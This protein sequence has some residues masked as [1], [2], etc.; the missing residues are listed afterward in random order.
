MP[1]PD[2]SAAPIIELLVTE[3]AAQIPAISCDLEKNYQTA[4]GWAG[5]LAGAGAGALTGAHFGIAGGPLGAIAGTVPG[6]IVG[7]IMGFFSG[8]KVGSRIDADPPVSSEAESLGHVVRLCPSCGQGVR[9]PV[10]NDG[11]VKCP[12]CAGTFRTTT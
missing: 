11:Q 3:A 2:S 6:A 9:L 10:G 1:Y 5:V 7:G 4:G 8:Q 12:Q